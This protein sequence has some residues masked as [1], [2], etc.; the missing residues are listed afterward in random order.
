MIIYVQKSFWSDHKETPN[1]DQT[2]MLKETRIQSWIHHGS[3]TVSLFW[4]GSGIDRI[5]NGEIMW[6][7]PD[8]DLKPDSD[9]LKFTEVD[10]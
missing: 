9:W 3:M 8:S 4:S 7:L 2:L 10:Q 1:P 6:I 5:P